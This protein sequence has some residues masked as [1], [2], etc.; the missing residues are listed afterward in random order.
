M[1]G[2]G[3]TNNVTLQAAPAVGIPTLKQSGKTLLDVAL[4][5]SASLTSDIENYSWDFTGAGT[6]NLTCY[7]HAN[8]N[9]SY[10]QAGLY[11]TTVTVIDAEGHQYKD[12]AIVNVMAVNAMDSI[13]QPIWNN[14]KNALNSNNISSALSYFESGARDKYANTFNLLQGHL[15]EIALDMSDIYLIRVTNGVAEYE[16]RKIEGGVEHAYFVK[17][18]Q[19]VDGVWRLSFY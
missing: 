1:T 15:S 10:E 7:S 8:V 9:V 12:A 2:T 4:R 6:S 5:S 19:D 17:F 11:L 16:M 13:F 14:V 3:A 18:V